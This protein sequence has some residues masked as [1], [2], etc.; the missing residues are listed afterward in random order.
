MAIYHLHAQVIQ[1]SKGKNAIAS[2]AYRRA[3]KLYD[4]KEQ[5][6]WNY[7]NKPDVIHSEIIVPENAPDWAKELIAIHEA[8]PSKA[9]EKI[10]NMVEAAEK[11][12]DAQLAREIEF[13]LPIELNQEQSI[14]LAR[15]F[16][17]DQ[18]VLRGM[19]ADWN[20]HWD[21]GNP[22]VHV[23]LSMR[24]LT[25]AGFGKR[26]LA[27]NNKALLREWREKWAEY[28][29]FHL[30]MYQHDVRIDHRSYQ[31][32]GIELIPSIHQGK[33]VSDMDRRG[34]STNIMSEA[35]EIRRE[36]LSRISAN[37]SVL[38]NKLSAHYESFT[39]QQ[40]G[41]E[42]GRYINDQGKFSLQEKG[43]SAET[44]LL[45]L[46]NF[47]QDVH[48]QEVLT[49]EIIAQILKS[50][51]HHE[52]VFT[53]KDIAK[54]VEPFTQNSEIF[55]K[56][57]VQLK[58]SPD[59]LYLGAGDDGHD[60][61][62][63]RRMFNLENEIQKTADLMRDSRHTKISA[64][65][66]HE[67]LEKHQNRIGKRL[68]DEQMIAVKHILKSSSISCI[69]GRAGT[70]K[71]FSLGAAKAVWEAQGLR[72]HG[73]ALSG[74]AADGLSKDAG[75][76]SR[77]IE[78]FRYALSKGTLTLNP[79]DV[80]VMDEAG[81]TDS[82]SMLAVL[83]A[84]RE[85]RAKLV[86]VGDHAQIQPVGPGASFRA[87][88]E[89]L[90]FAEIQTV[91]RQKEQWQR[92]A[93]V[94]F[95]TGRV[96]A[97]LA[98]YES[99]GCIHFEKMEHN[100]L[101]LLVND[102]LSTRAQHPKDLSQ[103][104]VIAHRNED[105][106]L[107]NRLLRAER[108]NK[109][110]IAEGYAVKA[111]LGEM[112]IAQGDRILFLKNDRRL[113]VSNGRFATIKS[114]DFTESGK[115]TSFTVLLDGTDKEVRI[116]PNE[117][118]DFAYGY[119]ATVHKVQGM[120]VD[121]AFV[122]AG[123]LGWNRHL[124]Y[125]ALSRHRETCHLYADKETHRERETL[126]R[127][128][129]RLGIKDSLLD[130]PLAFAERRGIDT[131]G[132]LKLLP[133]H[134]AERLKVWKE[135]ITEQLE[136][137]INPERYIQRRI[138]AARDQLEAEK[139]TRQREDARLVALYVDTNRDMGM[140]WQLL[141]AKLYALG[142][143]AMTYEKEAFDL[144]SGTQEY[145]AF[146]AAM[147]ARNTHAFQIMQDLSRYEKAVGIYELDLN[148]LK[149]QAEHHACYERVKQYANIC[150]K[151]AV[152]HRDRLASEIA[153]NIKWHYPYLQ[154]FQLDGREVKN[155][156][157]S[158]FKRQL[159][160]TLTTEERAAFKVIE[161]Y[162][163]TLQKLGTWWSTEVKETK[164]PLK[165]FMV[166]RLE[167]LSVARDHLAYQILKDRE[168][169]DR[170]LDFYQIGIATPHYG[171]KPTE[172]QIRQAEGRWYKLQQSAA[173]HEL[174]E[175]VMTYHQ[176]LFLGDVNTR[177]R[178]AYEI[179]Q[180][181]SAHHVAIVG[182]KSNTKEVWR[183]IRQDAKLYERYDHYR[184]LN[185]IDRTGF[186]T[187]ESYVEAKS[188]H[189]HAWREIFESKKTANL[190]EKTFYSTLASFA[191]RYTKERNQLAAKILE[192]P[193]HYQGGLDYFKITLEELQPQ[194][195]RHQ[196]HVNVE[197]YNKETNVL[198]CAKHALALVAD[199]KAHHGKVIENGLNWRDIYRDAHIAERKQHFD[200][201]NIEEKTLYRLADRYREVNKTA[202]RLF[203]RLKTR[204]LNTA[205]SLQDSARIDH[206]FAKRD[207]LA[208]R[209]VNRAY[210]INP[211]ILTEFATTC[212][213]NADKLLQQHARH[214]ERLMAVERCQSAYQDVVQSA[215]K[216]H[217]SQ[218]KEE[219][220]ASLQKAFTSVEVALRLQK[221]YRVNKP[222]SLDYALQLYGLSKKDLVE[223]MS[224]LSSLKNH[225]QALASLNNV[226][227]KK[228]AEKSTTQ[229]IST[230]QETQTTHQRMDIHRLREDLNARAEEVAQHYLGD[231]KTRSGSAWR[232]GTNKGSLVVTVRGQKQGL[233]RDFQTSEGGDMLNL[234]AHATG[235]TEFKEVL[236][237]ASRFLGGYSTY[238]QPIHKT[239]QTT[240]NNVSDLDAY[241]QQRIQKAQTIVHASKSVEGTLAERY[242]REH[243]G[244]QGELY[245]KTFRYHPGLKNWVT[246][247]VYPALVVV[248]R[249]EK[250]KVV[251][252]QAIFLDPKTAKKAPLGDNAKLSRGL[253]GEG[254]VVHQGLLSSKVAF[255]SGP[256]T[257]LS[258]AEAHPDWTVYVTFGVSNF[259]KVPLK[260]KRQDI[261]ICADNDGRDSGT[262][263]SVERAANILSR[264]GIDVWVA[265]PTK[266]S[267]EKKWD[268]NDSLI[269]QGAG[270]VK[271][272]LDNA[273]LYK[274]G[275]TQESVTK[276]VESTLASMDK[277]S[278]VF[279]LTAIPQTLATVHAVQELSFEMLLSHYVNMEL[280]QTRLVNAMHGAKLKD[281]TK[282][283][284]FSREALS[285]S[286][287]IKAFAACAINH[288]EIKA[289]IEKLKGIKPMTLAQ[290]GGFI[291]IRDRINK[292]EWSHEDKQVLVVQLRNKA[293][294][295]SRSQTR[296]RDRGG[297]SR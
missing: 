217:E 261:L 212:R 150:R 58:A 254:A 234:I 84:I 16:I 35:N 155:H 276:A 75:I 270:K 94:A 253:T 247:D 211:R 80:I 54:A 172:Q 222:E 30:R 74:I 183:A 293:L 260:A 49:P 151:G 78:S 100:A 20:V 171:E 124:T 227:E 114:V 42:L 207:Y 232:Y 142:L 257:A 77:T 51:E 277:H 110:E 70:G 56:A 292:G 85:A 106:N 37:P 39:G 177:I 272:D 267:N 264:Q 225:L 21:E 279:D 191:S 131:S 241:T 271:Q 93:T 174:R 107:L 136:Q 249:D 129:G 246:G 283:Q 282:A 115:V 266:P 86:L 160:K 1:R 52:S 228:I 297:R 252:V 99:Y 63:T 244:I 218:S 294:D 128:L 103:Y 29:N 149:N 83:K 166:E 3:A 265:E 184:H 125:V 162:Q 36:N 278:S 182:L 4:E 62:T 295:Q 188:A 87:L 164:E 111:K 5:K 12:K 2:A 168:R 79:Y 134:L 161:D 201:L 140:A 65:R 117:Y 119:A 208:W 280:E 48:S 192:N 187:I 123:G 14:L 255:G 251:G 291:A 132:L 195:H 15:E 18:F 66:I 68:T 209:L 239:I 287:T 200:R 27:W 198:L 285:H 141:Q 50:I 284:E 170:A 243:R 205:L 40:L 240:Q 139:I 41:Q 10:W 223:Q 216:I 204:T 43:K 96:P 273:V 231:P 288:P 17:H 60:R 213:L 47:N 180:A 113:G 105:V 127:H 157:V 90:G 89:R 138:N 197:N 102:W 67:V 263:K 186:K 248:A 158:H 219:T 286:S 281:P 233:W 296:D 224:G 226:D 238:I 237:E 259:D 221:I 59:L 193:S 268:F 275:I 153:Q 24:D 169:Y 167:K 126:Q 133:K 215:R 196:C 147:R 179:V 202:G 95:S 130:F 190:D 175:R 64:R 108:V 137:T 289:E 116:N 245:G 91:Y 163:A 118:R 181:T 55:A 178:L 258:I 144:I 230:L 290:R 262:A 26:V 112:K 206:A 23:M 229:V 57:I 53:E 156:A 154:S 7:T 122:Y 165:H 236:Q 152:V 71:S 73:V 46:E 185:L 109:S 76:Q 214:S 9:A 81:M 97:G 135:K 98:A 250:D 274:T 22:H 120:T 146:Q 61:F 8:H 121:H 72:V 25:E 6:D 104:L 19:I 189:A 235:T 220:T 256:E 31:D 203:S 148:K 13:A 45:N 101:S 92:D 143:D 145:L 210:S 11:R 33:A 44:A 194:A 82:V 173:R 32:Q 242:L 69:V 88:L 269:A 28:A 199:P 176:A 159:F 34:F 38:L